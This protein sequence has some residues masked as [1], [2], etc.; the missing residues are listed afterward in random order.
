MTDAIDIARMKGQ[1][2]ILASVIGLAAVPPLIAMAR[3]MNANGFLA[4]S[5]LLIGLAL[6]AGRGSGA[7][8]RFSLTTALMAAVMLISASLSG[9]PWQL[10]SH[11]LYFCALAGLVVFVDIRALILAVALVAVHHLSLSVTLPHLVYPSSSLWAD[12]ERAILH[13]VILIAE[14]AALIYAVWVRQNQ[15]RQ[16]IQDQIRVE[17]ALDDAHRAQAATEQAQAEQHAVVATLRENL[18]KLAERDLSAQ[19]EDRFPGEYEQLRTDYNA[20]IAEISSTIAA[21]AARAVDLA[22]G[23]RDITRASE[24]LSNRTE[25]QAATLE[26]TASALKSITASVKSAAD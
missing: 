1:R 5:G 8:A 19:I 4:T 12:V 22:E 20:A 26:E 3:G 21:V 7:L 14:A 25:N 11:M 15:S 23:A 17:E 10:D 16:A 9:H 6:I 24:E 13:G 18:T 2:I